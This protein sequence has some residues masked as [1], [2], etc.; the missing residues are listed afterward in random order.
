MVPSLTAYDLLFPQNWGSISPNIR[1]WPSVQRVIR[2]T[3][4][5]V[6]GYRV[7]GDCGSNGAIYGSN[8]SKMA[9]TAMLEKFQMAVS[10]QP[11]F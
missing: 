6:L 10:P 9:A 7:F 4:C 8:K 3:S 5:L 11:V 1:E 2:S